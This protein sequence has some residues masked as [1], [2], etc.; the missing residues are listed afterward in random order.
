MV[1]L[2]GDGGFQFTIGELASAVEAKVGLIVLLW[3]NEGYGEIK[4]YMVER[5]IAPIGVDIFT[6]DFLA[7]AKGFGCEAV[8][9]DSF[10]K[11]ARELTAA[12]ARTLPTIIEIR[13][14]APFLK[15]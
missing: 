6:P 11:L 5:Q 7:I 2:V 9:V 12:D 8:R 4:T 13:A 3:N 14:D 1:V 10:D 15:R